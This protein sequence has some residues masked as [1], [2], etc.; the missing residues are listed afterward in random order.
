MAVNPSS[1]PTKPQNGISSTLKEKNHLLL[2]FLKTKRFLLPPNTPFL[3]KVRRKAIVVFRSSNNILMV[4]SA[5]ICLAPVPQRIVGR[6]KKNLPCLKSNPDSDIANK[7]CISTSHDRCRSPLSCFIIHSEILTTS[8]RR[9]PQN[10]L[11][12]HRSIVIDLM[13]ISGLVPSLQEC[14]PI[15]VRRY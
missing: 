11:T 12:I 14:Q 8:I 3:L 13:S 1:P 9:S 7:R 2:A 6:K 15:H 5:R 4:I 10:L